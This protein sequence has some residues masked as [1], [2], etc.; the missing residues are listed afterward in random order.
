MMDAQT[1]LTLIKILVPI[2]FALAAYNTY[3]IFKL[4]NVDPFGDWDR[5]KINGT[6]LLLFF[7]IGAPLSIWGTW[8]YKDLYILITNPA[9]NHGV[10]I[11][12]LFWVTSAVTGFVFLVT[13]ALLFIF[14]FQYSGK[15]GKRA[16]F[17]PENNKLEII[18]TVIPAIVLT[19]LIASGV[20]TW[21]E[22]TDP[23]P[24][25]S[26]QIELTGKQ[27]DWTIRYPGADGKFGKITWDSINDASGNTYGYH[28][29]DKNS[30]DDF[31]PQE[32][33]LEVGVPVKVNI[34]ARDV[35]HCASFPHFRMK[36]DAV[37]GMTTSLWFTPT[38]TTDSMR[39]I[40][41]DP[42]FVYELACQEIC[43]GGHWN[44]RRVIS[45]DTKEQYAEWIKTQK[46]TYA[47]LLEAKNPAPV[48]DAKPADGAA[49][50]DSVAKTSPAVNPAKPAVTPQ[51]AKADAKGGA[52][53]K[54]AD[55]KATTTTPAAK[56]STPAV[57]PT[58]ATTAPKK[59]GKT[60]P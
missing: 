5:N 4:R 37:P 56:P 13:N 8:L 18:W 28:F 32:I 30:Q 58:A 39:M 54:P 38:I 55:A 29:S 27:F 42:K 43:G 53:A 45:I 31:N 19:L 2:V 20:S 7:L 23:S 17:Y 6:L 3:L 35:L 60:N 44:M 12:K 15:E 57:K 21:W 22:A 48:A 34:R 33:H 40:K 46:S 11:D 10:A 47:S 36:M 52:T 26:R 24:E 50:V 14:A 1:I 41:A 9:S 16:L 59:T 49:K 25:G 51:P